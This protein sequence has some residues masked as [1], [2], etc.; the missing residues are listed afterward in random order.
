[1]REFNYPKGVTPLKREEKGDSFPRR[2]DKRAANRGM[3]FES[4]IN[5]SN[6]YYREKGEALVYKR[7][8]PIKIVKVDYAHGAKIKEA[9]FEA[10]S[11]TDYNGVYKGHYLDF[12]AKEC[13]SMTSFPL[14]NI[15]PQQVEHLTAVIENGGW[16]F[17]LIRFPKLGETYFVPASFV[18]AF[19]KEGKR[20]S[21]PVDDIRKNGILLEEGLRPRYAYLK[22]ASSFFF[23]KNMDR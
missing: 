12:E 11:T 9:Y 6:A 18:L 22:A 20:K 10:Q 16:A 23:E 15:P 17:F 14:H 1:M 7:P 13:H 4:D 2:K 3:G 21:I 5:E 8:T 19:L